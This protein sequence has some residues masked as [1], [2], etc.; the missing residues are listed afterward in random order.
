MSM[1]DP[2]SHPEIP[3]ERLALLRDKSDAL[4][5]GAEKFGLYNQ[6]M[7]LGAA[8]D[9]VTGENAQ[10]MIVATFTIGDIA[11][12]DRVQRPDQEAV[13]NDLAGIET[14]LVREAIEADEIRQRL[15]ERR[16]GLT[17]ETSETPTESP[18]PDDG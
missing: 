13:N 12:S 14:D 10:L 3:E 1:S 7:Q 17:G 16:E 11:F 6:G 9:P 8:V 18:E 5:T 2:G 15:L 4:A